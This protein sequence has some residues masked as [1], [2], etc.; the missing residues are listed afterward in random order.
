MVHFGGYF[1]A[2]FTAVFGI[3]IMSERGLRD[4]QILECVPRLLARLAGRIQEIV[5]QQ[6]KSSLL[7]LRANVCDFGNLFGI[8]ICLGL[9]IRL[10]SA[11]FQIHD[12]DYDDYDYDYYIFRIQNTS[13]N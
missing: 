1:V 5:F 12:Y 2:P 13:F 7:D 10:P 6:T 8:A 11:V 4:L 9:P 3:K